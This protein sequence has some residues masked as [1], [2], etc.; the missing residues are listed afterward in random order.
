METKTNKFG[1]WL[2]NSITA[3]MLIVGFL[4]L[5]LLAPLSW[6]K[7]LI[8]ER[9]YRQSAVISE[10][11]D[12]WGNPITVYGPILKIPYK[13]YSQTTHYN[14]KT[15]TRTSSIKTT[16]KHAFVFPESLNASADVQSKILKRGNY[17]TSVFSTE[18]KFNGKF[19]QH[20]LQSKGIKNEDLIISKS[21][22]ILLT[23][24]LKGIKNEMNLNLNN[25][26]YGFETK[27]NTS[28]Q[29]NYYELETGPISLKDLPGTNATDFTFDISFNGSQS[30]QIIPIGKSTTLDMESNWANP[31][32]T[33]SFL[34]NDETKEITAKGFKANWKVLHINRAFSQEYVDQIPNISE[35]SFGTSFVNMVDEYQKSDRSAKYGFLVI[36]LTFLVF[37]LIQT[38]SKISIHPL[39][40]L[41]IG[42]ALIMFYTLLVSITEHSN[43]L[44]AYLIAG[45]SVIGLITIYSKSILKVMKFPVFIGS[46][47]TALYAFLFIIIQLETYALLAGS[48]GLFIILAVVMFVSRKIDWSNG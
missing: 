40:Y 2:R 11:E 6:V 47:L 38:I 44:K 18:I 26:V 31:S 1:H 36:I 45:T 10:I 5:L 15:K 43:F 9:S 34:P 7:E 39:Q 14:E 8:E 25:S 13:S 32:F 46:S 30:I 17:E 4:I 3:R 23:T 27:F 16:I 19:V 20:Q 35:F 42:L 12:K 24:N 33:G 48:I 28:T 22:V 37:F 21:T 41:M 29:A